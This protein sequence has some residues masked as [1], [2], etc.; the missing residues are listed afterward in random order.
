MR[1]NAMIPILLSLVLT[2]GAV[3]IVAQSQNVGNVQPLQPSPI[4]ASTQ[5]AQNATLSVRDAFL[6]AGTTRSTNSCSDT[7]CSLSA[8][9]ANTRSLRSKVVAHR[10]LVKNAFPG[11]KR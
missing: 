7:A 3:S 11:S 10:P 2:G 6:V 5:P 8:H 1:M 9:T 4:G